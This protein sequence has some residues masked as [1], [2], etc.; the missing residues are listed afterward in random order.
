MSSTITIR[1]ATRD[2]IPTIL[3][4]I[5]ELAV[6]EHLEKEVTATP[7]LLEEWLFEKQKAEVIFACTPEGTE[8]GIAVFFHSFSTFLGKGGIYLEDLFVKPQF[9][10]RGFGKAL[11]SYLA[12]LTVQRGCGR[13]EWACL[14]WNQNAID[15]YHAWGA[16]TLDDWTTFRLTGEKLK[17]LGS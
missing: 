10:R 15:F 2:D 16:S 1:F 5:R 14:D 11:L 4:F 7:E 6:Y 3:D 8:A 17:Q 13:L 9:R 12:K